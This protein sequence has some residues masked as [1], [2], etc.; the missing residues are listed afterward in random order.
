MPTGIAS[1]NR[2]LECSIAPEIPLYTANKG[3]VSEPILLLWLTEKAETA[4][5]AAKRLQHLVVPH[6]RDLECLKENPPQ[7]NTQNEFGINPKQMVAA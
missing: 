6:F 1:W 3:H 2:G 4:V 5:L 7:K